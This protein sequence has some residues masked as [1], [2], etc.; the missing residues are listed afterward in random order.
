MV[1]K[2]L[3][4][5]MDTPGLWNNRSDFA[6]QFQVDICDKK[7]EKLWIELE[8]DPKAIH[9]GISGFLLGRD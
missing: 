7:E 8:R 9:S 6:L 1:L 5:V 4:L 3:S 2:L